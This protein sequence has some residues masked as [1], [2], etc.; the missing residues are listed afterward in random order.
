MSALADI[1]AEVKA[2]PLSDLYI[3]LQLLKA[4]RKRGQEE[5]MKESA[6][7]LQRFYNREAKVIPFE[8]KS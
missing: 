3:G 7:N 5:K 4:H 8:A 6:N 2:A 1:T